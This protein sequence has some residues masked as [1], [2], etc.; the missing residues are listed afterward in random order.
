MFLHN[1]VVGTMS[2]DMHAGHVFSS[3]VNSVAENSIRY[4]RTGNGGSSPGGDEVFAW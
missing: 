4:L 2:L 1:H 3:M